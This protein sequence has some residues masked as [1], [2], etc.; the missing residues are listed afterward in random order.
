M[1]THIILTALMWTLFTVP[2]N[3]DQNDSAVLEANVVVITV[4]GIVCS[5]C[6][7]GIKKNLAKL[8]SVDQTRLNKGIL[9]NV[10]NQRITVAIK[11]IPDVQGMFDAVLSGGYEPVS[12]V[13]IDANGHAKNIIVG[14]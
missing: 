4:H 2:L 11:G 12:A 6:A 10:E 7:Q 1:K 8:A 13:I 3:A 14:S 9:M 5:F